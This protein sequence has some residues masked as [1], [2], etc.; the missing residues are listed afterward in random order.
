VNKFAMAGH[1]S[2]EMEEWAYYAT[3]PVEYKRFLPELA[4]G[5]SEAAIRHAKAAHARATRDGV[6]GYQ[7]IESL[8]KPVRQQRKMVE[9][10]LRFAR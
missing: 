6:T 1:L 2:R 3:C 7:G 8:E 5:A 9:L 10:P 4:A